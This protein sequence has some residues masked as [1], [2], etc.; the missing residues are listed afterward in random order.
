MEVY[1]K[2]TTY[3]ISKHKNKET[4]KWKDIRTDQ[5]SVKREKKTLSKDE[6][7]KAKAK[8]QKKTSNDFRLVLN[9]NNKGTFLNTVNI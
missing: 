9:Q 6:Y 3:V 4:I 1:R 5:V 7:L 2:V 8:K